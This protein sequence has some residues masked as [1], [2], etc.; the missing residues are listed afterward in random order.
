[1]RSCQ[2]ISSSV[3]VTVLPSLPGTSD[4]RR[5]TLRLQLG[6]L[7]AQGVVGLFQVPFLQLHSLHVLRERTDLRLVLV[8]GRGWGH[9][10][11]KRTKDLTL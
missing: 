10:G 6:Q 8:W 7:V 1:M 5:L 2:A 9:K 11:D 3:S 4:P